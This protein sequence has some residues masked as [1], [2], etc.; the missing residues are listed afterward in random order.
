M[1]SSRISA[2]CP[3]VVYE[4][5]SGF[6]VN[7]LSDFFAIHGTYSLTTTD[8]VVSGTFTINPGLTWTLTDVN[9][10]LEG[11]AQIVISGTG[12][13]DALRSDFVDCGTPWRQIQVSPGAR[14]LA[15][16]CE[17]RGA[18]AQAVHVQHS[19]QEVRLTNNL[20]TAN[21]TCLRFVGPQ[22]P[23]NHTVLNNRLE[24]SPVA[25]AMATATNVKIDYNLYE[26]DVNYTIPMVGVQI[27]NCSNIT[28]NS[29]IMRYLTTGVDASVSN[30]ILVRGLVVIA[31]YG[32]LA[33]K[34]SNRFQLRQNIIRTKQY[35][36]NIT[37]HLTSNAQ[38]DTMNI[39]LYKNLVASEFN[40]AIRVDKTGGTGTVNV[41]SNT[42]Y[43]AHF[44][45]FQVYGIEVANTPSAR[46][47]IRGNWVQHYNLYG[48]APGGIYVWRSDRETTVRD[49][50]VSADIYGDMV[51]GITVAQ[52]P[53]CLIVGDTVFGGANI[54]ERGI[55]VEMTPEDIMLC[56]NR[57]DEAAR[58]LNM[59]GPHENCSIF[60][61]TFYDHT[62]AL[63]Y[64]MV[65]SSSAP[66]THRGNDWSTASTTWDAYYNGNWLLASNVF[67]TV[68]PT[69]L[70]SGLTKVF[71]TGGSASDWFDISIGVETTCD[72]TGTLAGVGSFCDELPGGE[73]EWGDS[74]TGNDEWAAGPLEDEHYAALHWASQRHLFAKL[75]RS[76]GLIGH[77]ESISDFYAAA[78]AGNLA[79][80]HDVDAG[81][82]RLYEV[83]AAIAEAY[84]AAQ[85]EITQLGQDLA[86]LDEAISNAQSEDIPALL[87][88]REAL[89]AQY[90]T[91]AAALVEYEA[92]RSAAAAEQIAE[93][94]QWNAAIE[95]A[96]DHEADAKAMNAIRLNALAQNDW[97]F[98]AAE[99]A[100]IDAVAARCPKYSGPA[101]YHARFLQEYYRVPDWSDSDCTPIS[102]RS[103]EQLISA[104]NGL[105]VYP[106]PAA[107]MV[108]IEL[109]RP[110][111]SECL[112]QIF[113]LT[114]QLILTERLAEGTD[115]L[116][117]PTGALKNGHYTLLLTD[118]SRSLFRHKLVILR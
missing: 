33:D 43:P 94:L 55:S 71:V 77:S 49:N 12:T 32:I 61:T 41:D 42:I 65:V 45:T 95:P 83:P 28:I 99:K 101:V 11:N 9:V 106:N 56:C 19:P 26:S 20:F 107:G 36:V 14:M 100:A 103:T 10:H 84:W 89:V 50:R 96:A 102:E 15:H 113:N 74:I 67:Y 97:D 3:S 7:S 58:G 109:E 13:L 52:S 81:L 2:Q 34:C 85:A 64:D 69:L 24:F 110:A 108:Q 54:M 5:G 27:S 30:Q 87:A 88:Q 22:N 40:T 111:A 46:V 35:G 75:R 6:G 98:D 48:S 31:N 112:L 114:G 79:L 4:A 104:T 117:L 51:F 78:E 47:L 66:Q 72:G 115:K 17:F 25:I 29:G 59:M 68:D 37:N 57:V 91:A 80:F 92:Q 39:H 38:Q 63:Y 105:R 18:N 118:N 70:P 23:A 73:G 76:P 82:A 90:E 44:S 53:N 62:E 93:L 60:N 1:G 16:D 21:T 86:D 116:T 8:V